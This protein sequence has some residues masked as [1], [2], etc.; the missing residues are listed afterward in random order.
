MLEFILS[1]TDTIRLFIT[2][3]AILAVLVGA[4]LQQRGQK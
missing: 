3:A 1:D 4:K 2:L